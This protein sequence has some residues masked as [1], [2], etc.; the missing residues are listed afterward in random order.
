MDPRD[1]LPHR[2][3]FLFLN[4]IEELGDT[5]S[6]A[7]YC[8]GPDEPYFRGHFPGAPVVPGVIQIEVMGQLVVA[9]GLYIA[10]K[11]NVGQIGSIFLVRVTDCNFYRPLGPGDEVIVSAHCEWFRLNSFQAKAR[12]TLAET[13]ELCSEAVIRGGARIE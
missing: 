5:T 10:R 2:E 3:P 7:R 6:R 12:L 13:G 11:R 4:E 9:M 8:F 1:I